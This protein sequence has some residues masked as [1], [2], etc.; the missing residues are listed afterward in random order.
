MADN[1][2]LHALKMLFVQNVLRAVTPLHDFK[3]VG[4]LECMRALLSCFFV[5][6][7]NLACLRRTFIL[8]TL[9]GFNECSVLR[10]RRPVYRLRQPPQPL[11]VNE[12]FNREGEATDFWEEMEKLYEEAPWAPPEGDPVDDIQ[13]RGHDNISAALPRRIQDE[14]R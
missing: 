10:C 4:A 14:S 7:Y 11:G 5:C 8:H 1:K 3:M 6:F 2:L 9:G 13:T 12:W